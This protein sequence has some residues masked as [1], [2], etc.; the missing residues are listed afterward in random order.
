MARWARR[1]VPGALDCVKAWFEAHLQRDPKLSDEEFLNTYVGH[2]SRVIRGLYL[3]FSMYCGLFALACPCAE[4]FLQ[5]GDARA[6]Q[7]CLDVAEAVMYR[8]RRNRFGLLAHDDHWQ[9]DIPDACFLNVQ[10]LMSA[11]LVAGPAD[12]QAF[13]KHAIAQLRAYIDV[14]LNRTT[15]LAH[16]V[17]GPEGL[18]RTFWCRA[19]GWIMWS[20]IAVLRGMPAGH[21]ELARFKSDLAFL[22]DG[23]AR[24]TDADGAIHAFADD[25]LSPQETTG[26]A[27]V[28]LAL[29]ESVRHGWLP[30]DRHVGSARR[31]WDFI[32]RHVTP[33]GGLE[34]V[35]NQ[36]A[37][38]AEQ[39][40]P[41]S[42][43]LYDGPHIGTLL[44]LAEEMT[45]P[46][47]G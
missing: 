23:L 30:H 7:A 18:G 46:L 47:E 26:T 35:Y 41:S 13:V 21:P 25:T 3:P 17:L 11:A 4:L 1:G 8:A 14:F 45:T 27:M 16:T 15:G 22:A 24:V 12:A 34:K 36:W 29:H 5:A 32:K 2:P 43:T 6:R 37:L 38:P 31:M 20:F 9:Y 42:Q 39:L 19:Q 10:P 40:V 33:D 28:A 44:W